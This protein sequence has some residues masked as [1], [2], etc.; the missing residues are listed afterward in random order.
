MSYPEFSVPGVPPEET[1]QLFNV[2]NYAYY[3]QKVKD[4][5]AGIC[6]FCQIDPAVNQVLLQNASWLMW[7]NKM[8]PRSGQAHQFIFPLRRHVQKVNELTSAEWADLR[9][10]VLMAEQHFQVFDGALVM[11]S[12]D[13][14]KNAK[15]VPHFHLNYQVPT[16]R[17]R[18]EVTF[19]KSEA[20]LLKK[21]AVLQ[22]FEKLRLLEEAGNS[23]PLAQ[24]DGNELILV[25]GKLGAHVF[26]N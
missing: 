16:G 24:L 2:S 11:R 19:A 23:N 13:P 21:V 15:S 14:L 22:V 8:A 1:W 7:Q 10:I 5:A 4:L 25:D 20:D 26:K 18:V 3:L 12:G 6:P 9:D 17:D